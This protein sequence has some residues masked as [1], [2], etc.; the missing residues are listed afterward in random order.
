VKLRTGWL[1][2][3]GVL[4][5][6]G[7]AL[8]TLPAT[9]LSGPLGRAGLT[10]SG[11]TGSVWSGTAH[12]FAWRGV[13]LGDLDWTLA[14]LELLSGRAAGH[15]ELARVD[16]AVDTDFDVA[17]FG[18][19]DLRLTNAK[20]QLPL[21]ALAALPFGTAKGWRGRATGVFEEVRVADG[22]PVALQGTLDL[23]GLVAPPPRNTPV[24]SFHVVFPHPRPQP[25]LSI[26]A[27][28]GNLTAQV[29]D[30]AGSLAVDGQFTLSR[31]RNF[32]LEGTLAPRGPIPPDLAR[33]L[34]LLG[35][36]D[37]AG[38]RQFSVGGSVGSD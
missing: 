29:R 21:D 38:R 2:A 19:R 17:L 12:G 10:A 23:D 26:P 16:G 7:F 9:V 15:L 5:L 27:D 18:R 36:A 34:Q 8:A 33:S 6:L 32:S 14:P 4:A 35:P 31:A 20:L 22:W 13:E 37:P 28:A 30:K 11:F 1:V 25:S 24:G 3:L